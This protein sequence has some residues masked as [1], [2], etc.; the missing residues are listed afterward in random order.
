MNV[1]IDAAGIVRR[2]YDETM[3]LQ[4]LGSLHIRRASHAEPT[5]AGMWLADLAP[6]NGPVLGPFSSRREALEAERVWAE[7]SCLSGL[8]VDGVGV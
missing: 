4:R 3:E 6:V 1:F 5:P 7:S 8:T 2:L